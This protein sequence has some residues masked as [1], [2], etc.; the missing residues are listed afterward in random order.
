VGSV[1]IDPPLAIPGGEGVGIE[2]PVFA[3]GDAEDP[4]TLFPEFTTTFPVPPVT[5]ANIMQ[6]GDEPPPMIETTPPIN[7]DWMNVPNM[8]VPDT[9]V[10]PVHQRSADV[11]ER[12]ARTVLQP[13]DTHELREP[14]SKKDRK[15]KRVPKGRAARDADDT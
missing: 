1:E 12:P 5:E 4:A 10:E 14:K 15:R 11:A 3:T 8:G 9:D 7:I 6:V 13:A 2:Q